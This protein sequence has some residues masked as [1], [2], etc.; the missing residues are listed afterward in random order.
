MDLKKMIIELLEDADEE[1]L[2][3]IYIFVSN[4]S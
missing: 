1:T 3:L 2:R 4:L